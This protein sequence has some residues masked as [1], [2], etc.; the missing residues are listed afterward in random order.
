MDKRPDASVKIRCYNPGCRKIFVVNLVKEQDIPDGNK[1]EISRPCPYCGKD[2]LFVV[3]ARMVPV[4][5]VYREV[6]PGREVE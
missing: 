3:E 2:N 1:V 6:I 5:S 4:D